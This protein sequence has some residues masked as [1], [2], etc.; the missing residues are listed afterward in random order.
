[1]QIL[2]TQ[3]GTLFVSLATVTDTQKKMLFTLT[4]KCHQPPYKV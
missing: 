2:C 4:T 1:M 3:M